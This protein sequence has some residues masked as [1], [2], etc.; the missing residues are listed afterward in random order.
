VLAAT[1]S[2]KTYMVEAVSTNGGHVWYCA[3]GLSRRW[4]EMEA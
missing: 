3:P 4:G 1:R 2:V